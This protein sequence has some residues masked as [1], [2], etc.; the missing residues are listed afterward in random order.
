MPEDEVEPFCL[1]E[2]EP[3]E[4]AGAVTGARYDFQYHQAAAA[5]LEVLDDTDVACVYCE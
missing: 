2:V 1:H 3:R 5:A 4:Q